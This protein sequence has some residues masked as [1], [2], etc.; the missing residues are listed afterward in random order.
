MYDDMIAETG[1][2]NC[3][4]FWYRLA[5]EVIFDTSY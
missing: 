3:A 1:M 5:I 4:E 2:Q